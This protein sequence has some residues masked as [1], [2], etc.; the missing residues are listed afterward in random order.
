MGPISPF[1]IPGMAG[2]LQRGTPMEVPTT[3]GGVKKEYAVAIYLLDM[4][5]VCGCVMYIIYDYEY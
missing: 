3:K 2:T 4:L 1:E 5:H